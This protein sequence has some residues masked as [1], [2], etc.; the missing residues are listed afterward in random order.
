MSPE[1]ESAIDVDV[2]EANVGVALILE[3][4]YCGVNGDYTFTPQ[5]VSAYVMDGN[6][7]KRVLRAY[8]LR[9]LPMAMIMYLFSA[10]DRGNVSNAK[11]DGMDK[12]L[13]FHGNQY[14]IMLTVFFVP[15]CFMA[16]PGT[17]L[18]KRFGA[19]LMLPLYMFGWGVMALAN[20]AVKNFAQCLVVRLLLGMFE[21][22]FGASLI[23]YLACFYTRGELG[24]RMAAWYS[25]VAVSGAFSGLLSFGLFQIESSLHGWQMLF[26]IEG[27]LT[28]IIAGVAYFVLPPWAGEAGFLSP[29]E[30]TVGVMRLLRDSSDTVNAKMTLRDYIEPAKDW[31]T[32]V[33][34]AYCLIY[35]VAN[36]TASTFLTQ[37]VGR[38]GYSKVK[39]NLLTVGP[40][41]VATVVLW[42]FVISSDRQ[43]ERTIHVMCANA[44][45]VIGTIVL[46]VTPVSNHK[47]GYFCTFL[48]A[49][50]SFIPSC[51]WQSFVQN[52]TTKEN[53]KAFR[54]S[55]M[56]FGANAGGIVSANIFLEQFKPKYVQP[57]IISSAIAA[58]GIV[59]LASLRTYM[60]LQNSQ[61]NKAQ[62]V[63]WTSLDVPTAALNEGKHNP[64]YR[65]FL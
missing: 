12:D 21:G 45:V 38:F 9:I 49:S 62:G 16:Y 60:A 25:M 40:Y 50:G 54:S 11:S 44:L 2:K 5:E 64:S 57:L 51:L 55:V 42:L 7:A 41:S 43:R 23:M 27:G 53:S 36:S 26:L 4:D 18:T 63:N 22:C 58:S 24:K 59:V 13:G 37:I 29:Q 52:N 56:N 17:Y 34:G 3:P 8:D 31:E 46:A 1:K 32:W 28:V 47:V 10:L 14:N 15:F 30:K 19:K 6:V 48:I 35:G 61:R 33:W 65:Y 20:A 39:T